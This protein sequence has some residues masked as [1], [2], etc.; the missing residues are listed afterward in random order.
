MNLIN[1]RGRGLEFSN[2]HLS[3]SLHCF[4][5]VQKISNTSCSD[6]ILNIHTE[7][8]KP[9]YDKGYL[10]VMIFKIYQVLKNTTSSKLTNIWMLETT[11]VIKFAT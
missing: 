6:V 1:L 10:M 9:G 5:S 3:I 11:Y 8:Y 4:I 7:T 2:S